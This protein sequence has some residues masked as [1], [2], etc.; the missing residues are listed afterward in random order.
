M[1]N[2]YPKMLDPAIRAHV[3]ELLQH[4]KESLPITDATHDAV[5]GYMSTIH[6]ALAAGCC[7][8]YM[9]IVH[10]G[11]PIVTYRLRNS[12]AALGAIA[13]DTD[14]TYALEGA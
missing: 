5:C 12:G 13:C 14:E 7:E 2:K 9:V 8:D 11:S 1:R 4:I 6:Q 10:N 3:K